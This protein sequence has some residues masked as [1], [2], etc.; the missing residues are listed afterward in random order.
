MDNWELTRMNHRKPTLTAV[1]FL[2]V[3]STSSLNQMYP[4]DL[5]DALGWN[6]FF[7]NWVQCDFSQRP[8]DTFCLLSPHFM[9][10]TSLET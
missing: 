1:L 7:V 2:R 6:E 9:I 8:A 10:L 3:H 4:P 5:T